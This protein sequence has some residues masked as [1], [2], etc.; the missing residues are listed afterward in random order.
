M[1][2]FKQRY[3][4]HIRTILSDLLNDDTVNKLITEYDDLIRASVFED[5]KK[6]TT[7]TAYTNEINVLKNFVKNRRVNLLANI[8]VK[9]A[10]PQIE[11]VN[12]IVNGQAYASVTSKDQ[13]VVQ[14]AINYEPG[15]HQV[16]L[17]YGIGINS[18]FQKIEMHD[19]GKEGD[20][21]AG[22]QTWS[23][24]LP[25]FL[26]GT[27]VKFY[28]EAIGNDP[29]KS[30]R[31]YPAGAEHHLMIFSVEPEVLLEKKVV[32]NEFMASNSATVKDEAGEYEDWIELFNPT[33]E[34]ADLS[35]YFITD[36]PANL[37]KF[38]L[39]I[40]TILKSGEYMII[41]ADE[42][43][44]QGPLHVN[45]KLAA[46]GETILLLNT[47]QVIVDHVVFGQQTENKSSARKPNGTGDFTIGNHTFG[48][49][50]DTTSDTEEWG[51]TTFN[52]Y[53]NPA[54][55]RITLIYEGKTDKK[56]VIFGLYGNQIQ[57]MDVHPG[58]IHSFELSP[59]VY[60]LQ[61]GRV[62]KKLIVLPQ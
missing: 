54:V 2:A 13:V 35:G 58:Q 38:K 25:S 7:N 40:G 48:Y 24:R 17:H 61:L 39:P 52:V 4:A 11:N 15:I 28:I 30:R 27:L 9:A 21:A 8:E 16:W 45:F 37:T 33:T 42:D 10:S 19:D 62:R 26:P 57:E 32:I 41:W 46:G 50:N 31:Y 34:D 49:N 43:Q 51:L 3:L 23:V 29:V 12:Y 47:Q 53:P 14:T 5:P 18:I 20:I 6:L 56:L 44:E 36:N 59:G 55:D 22:D 60:L 1:P